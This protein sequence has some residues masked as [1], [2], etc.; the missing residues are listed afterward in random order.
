[1]KEAKIPTSDRSDLH[2]EA[3]LQDPA[4][5]KEVLA[6][7]GYRVFFDEADYWV[8]TRPFG[9]RVVLVKFPHARAV[10]RWP[11]PVAPKEDEL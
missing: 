8:L 6:V 11:P 5:F 4:Q 2:R 7:A 10:L 3:T 1:M 9:L